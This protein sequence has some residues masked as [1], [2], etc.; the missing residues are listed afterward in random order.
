MFIRLKFF[1]VQFTNFKYD[2]YEMI[3]YVY[4]MYYNGVYFE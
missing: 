2:G 3:K 1:E 4:N